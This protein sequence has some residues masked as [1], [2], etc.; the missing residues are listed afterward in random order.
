MSVAALHRE[1]LDLST[2][3]RSLTPHE[4]QRLNTVRELLDRTRRRRRHAFEAYV[5]DA[6][7]V[8]SD[9]PTPEGCPACEGTGIYDTAAAR[10]R[11]R[12]LDA[13]ARR[14]VA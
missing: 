14:E 9:L 8:C 7:P 3:L 1:F 10:R 6:C 13:A 11:E 4:Q 2:M 12:F 5:V